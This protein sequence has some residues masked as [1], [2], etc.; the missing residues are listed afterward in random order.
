[1]LCV[2]LYQFM[3]SYLFY[4]DHAS[5]L[6]QFFTITQEERRNDSWATWSTLIND[7][8]LIQH[9]GG[10]NMSRA[11]CNAPTNEGRPVWK[12]AESKLLLLYQTYLGWSKKW[13]KPKFWL[14]QLGKWST[15]SLFRF[16]KKI[17]QT[18]PFVSLWDVDSVSMNV[19]HFWSVL[20]CGENLQMQGIRISSKSSL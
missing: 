16:P 13:A 5:L 1:M 7:F 11:H 9:A 17:R 4:W 20:Y 12:R 15:I 2:W 8:H 14:F 10:S 19:D 18:N 6:G 3:L